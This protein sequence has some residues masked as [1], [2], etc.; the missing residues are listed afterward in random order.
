M[1]FKMLAKNSGLYLACQYPNSDSWHTISE[2]MFN[3][4]WDTP[5]QADIGQ[6]LEDSIWQWAPL[7][8]AIKGRVSNRPEDVFA[9]VLLAQRLN[10]RY[11][12]KCTQSKPETEVACAKCPPSCCCC[13]CS[14]CP[15]R[16]V[17]L[18]LLLLTCLQFRLVF[19]GSAWLAF[20]QLTEIDSL[21]PAVPIVQAPTNAPRLARRLAGRNAEF[22]K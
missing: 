4:N 21:C 9:A 14:R 13:C 17:V 12:M 10:V 16:A 7:W 6:L 3:S 1:H 11:K 15:R 2:H 18:L 19:S 20:K 5:R 8:V 22:C